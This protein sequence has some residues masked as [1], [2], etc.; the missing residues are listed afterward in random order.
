MLKV[1]FQNKRLDGQSAGVNIEGQTPE[2]FLEARERILGLLT[3]E[4][5]PDRMGEL[6]VL[7]AQANSAIKAFSEVE[8]AR[9]EGERQRRLLADAEAAQAAE[10]KDAYV[11]NCETITRAAARRF[12]KLDESAWDHSDLPYFTKQIVPYYRQIFADLSY[13]SAAEQ[14][15]EILNA[16]IGRREWVETT[17]LPRPKISR[18]DTAKGDW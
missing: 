15:D 2:Q 16:S 11:S 10:A 14:A 13:D 5:D 17:K 3:R 18:R 6:S 1:G 4:R 9:C 12:A 8:L 7:L